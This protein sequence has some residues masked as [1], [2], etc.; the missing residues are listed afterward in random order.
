MTGAGSENK[1]RTGDRDSGPA[2][3]PAPVPVVVVTTVVQALATMCTM[4]PAAIAPEMAQAFGVPASLIGFQVSLVY[5]GAMATSV[6]GGLGVRRLG[7]LRISQWA[8][9]FAGAGVLLAAVPSLVGLAVGSVLIGFGY[10]LTNPAGAHLLMRVSKP[11]NRNLIFSVKQTGVPLGGVVAGLAAAP[12]ALTFG[13][14]GA[15][16]AGAAAALAFLAMIQPLRRAWDEDRDPSVSLLQDPMGDFRLIWRHPVLRRMSMASFCFSAVQVSLTTFA[17]T[18]LV[19][20]IHFGLVQAGVV[21]SVVLVA[22][23]SG[24]LLWGWIAD[25]V[26]DANRVL[27]GV[28]LIAASAGLMTVFLDAGTGKTVLYGVLCLFGLSAIGWNG[29]FLAEIARLAPSGR[30]GSA[31]G[32]ALV[33]T[34]AGV[35]VGPASFAGVFWLAGQYTFTFGVFALVSL[36]GFAMILAARRRLAGD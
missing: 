3:I 5:L 4:I 6:I 18:M 34:Y 15:L 17:V 36:A 23:G 11:E 22:G 14:Q 27:L 8:L 2:A 13:W 1:H 21:L 10:G 29:V 19:E 31:T 32:G 24:R 30:I 7:A 35:L 9:G 26:G 33:P 28:A 25:R 16:L 20:D 12:L